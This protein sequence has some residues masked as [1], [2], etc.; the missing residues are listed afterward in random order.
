MS[1][2]VVD[3]AMMCYGKP[4]ENLS[5]RVNNNHTL[6]QTKLFQKE[7]AKRVT[8]PSIIFIVLIA[9]ISIALFSML[10]QP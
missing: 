5:D 9:R 8:F 7:Q 10:V 2:L 1:N 3:V 6:L 4:C